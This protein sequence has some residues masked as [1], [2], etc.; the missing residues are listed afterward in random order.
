MTAAQLEPF[1]Q[2][3]P[4]GAQ[5]SR[6]ESPARAAGRTSV[7]LGQLEDK[8][9]R[10]EQDLEEARRAHFP[11]VDGFTLRFSYQSGT[12]SASSPSCSSGSAAGCSA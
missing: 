8:L 5:S 9:L 6:D 4:R 1:Q 11:S 12:T 7:K 10:T 3:A 2:A